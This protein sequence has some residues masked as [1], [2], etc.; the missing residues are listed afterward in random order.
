MLEILKLE[1][2][3]WVE[4]ERKNA[5]ELRIVLLFLQYMN[6]ESHRTVKK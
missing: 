2:C 1:I 4:Y 6:M 5:A 3:S